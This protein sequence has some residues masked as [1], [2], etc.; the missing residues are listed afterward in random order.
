M[1]L[2]QLNY[3]TPALYGQLFYAILGEFFSS[4]LEV[5]HFFHFLK[6]KIHWFTAVFH[7]KR[8]TGSFCKSTLSKLTVKCPTAIMETNYFWNYSKR[9][10]LYD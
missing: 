1:I 5:F 2:E 6:V 10:F 8:K 9:R 4:F 7:R 3:T